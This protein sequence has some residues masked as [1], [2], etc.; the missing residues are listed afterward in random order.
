[1]I[2]NDKHIQMEPGRA[3]FGP[4]RALKIF[5]ILPHKDKGSGL[6][7]FVSGHNLRVRERG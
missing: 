7:T 2:V 6:E 4:S 3:V 1:M 5:R